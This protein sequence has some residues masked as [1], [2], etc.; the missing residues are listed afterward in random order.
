MTTTNETEMVDVIEE[1]AAT[2]AELQRHA[3]AD[4]QLLQSILLENETSRRDLGERDA[5]IARLAADVRERIALVLEASARPLY[6][7][8][9]DPEGHALLTHAARFVRNIPI[10][11]LAEQPI[12]T[13]ISKR[14]LDER[15]AELEAVVAE[16]AADIQLIK[17][18][19]VYLNDVIAERDATIARLREAL[20]GVL[21]AF[22][23]SAVRHA[24]DPIYNGQIS[25][26]HYQEAWA[27]L[28]EEPS[29]TDFGRRA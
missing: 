3:D 9:R 8:K 14:A 12:M 11:A 10:A 17:V 4:H 16:R 23:A 13:V 26:R 25:V 20:K 7:Q 6:E 15:I 27:A 1:Q 2:I 24:P 22:N 19:V 5:T 29:P 28:A 18:E 21:G